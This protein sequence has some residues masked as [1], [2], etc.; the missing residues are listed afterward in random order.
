MLNPLDPSHIWLTPARQRLA[1]FLEKQSRRGMDEHQEQAVSEGSGGTAVNGLPEALGRWMSAAGY[2]RKSVSKARAALRALVDAWPAF[3]SSRFASMASLDGFGA[4]V[5]SLPEWQRKDARLLP[6]LLGLLEEDRVALSAQSEFF[7]YHVNPGASAFGFGTERAGGQPVGAG[8]VALK[9]VG[10]YKQSHGD[11]SIDNDPDDPY[12][13]VIADLPYSVFP[14]TD[15]ELAF[16]IRTAAHHSR[17]ARGALFRVDWSAAARMGFGQA[18]WEKAVADALPGWEVR[19]VALA[20]EHFVPMEGAE[21]F[22]GAAKSW[23]RDFRPV[24]ADIDPIPAASVLS[25]APHTG[26]A[27][28]PLGITG[29]R[30]PKEKAG[31]ID[32]HYPHAPQAAVVGSGND[33]RLLFPLEIMAILGFP[34]IYQLPQDMSDAYHLLGES[35]AVPV[36]ERAVRGFLR[37][38]GMV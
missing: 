23:A 24:L 20:N 36:A 2:A 6:R 17:K 26:W 25:D 31:R 7:F 38:L 35:V 16:V 9:A 34:D 13:I 5:E 18:A 22:I 8:L 21:L 33:A 12:D 32:A 29:R 11:N 4:A 28:V 10:P 37:A 3:P 30:F 1:S 19:S 27:A 15:P 14:E